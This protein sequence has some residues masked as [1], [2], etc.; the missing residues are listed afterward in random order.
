M[1]YAIDAIVSGLLQALAIGFLI[2][3]E[4]ESRAVDSPRAAAPGLRDFV[5]IALTGSVAGFLGATLFTALA[6][7]AIVAVILVR[8]LKDP[9]EHG[10][11]TEIAALLTF[12]LGLLTQR[13]PFGMLALGSAVG[14]TI[15]LMVKDPITRLVREVI[16]KTELYDTVKFLA[17]VFIVYPLLPAGEYGLYGFFMPRTIWKFV[18]LVSSVSYVGYFLTRFIGGSRGLLL[19]GVVGALASTTATISAFAEGAREYPERWRDYAW[20]AIIANAIQ[21]PRVAVIIYVMNAEL[22]RAAWRPLTVMLAAGLVIGSWQ[23]RAARRSRGSEPVA[24]RPLLRNPFS[25]WPAV[26]FG[27]IF[28]AILFVAKVGAVRFGERGVLSSSLVGGL[29]DVD[30]ISISLAN[31]VGAG[32]IWP[33]VGCLAVLLA[34][35]ANGVFKTGIAF[36]AGGRRFGWTLAFAFAVMFALG[37]AA[38]FLV[39]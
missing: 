29:I 20:A 22:A 4:R 24:A 35:L 21:F 25:L 16:S 12:W 31:L 14:V 8:R 23:A 9:T 1:P 39:R 3:A 18:I 6:F 15:I 13:P 34:L 30:A 38:A 33:A 10:I 11:T 37:F 27:L 2:G 5:L 19:T 7:A 26:Q 17:I 36:T 32:E 28:T